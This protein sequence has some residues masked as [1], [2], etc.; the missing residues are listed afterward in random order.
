MIE[1]QIEDGGRQWSGVASWSSR[2]KTVMA[3]CRYSSRRLACD[4][5]THWGFH[6]T[7]PGGYKL[8]H[9]VSPLSRWRWISGGQF[10]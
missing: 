2:K 3:W 10:L 5:A 6:W 8:T 9:F 1:G 4:A 7:D